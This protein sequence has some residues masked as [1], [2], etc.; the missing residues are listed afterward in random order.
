M[1]SVAQP[2]TRAMGKCLELLTEI[3]P[4]VKRAALIFNPDTAPGGRSYYYLRP[5]QTPGTPCPW[6]R[7]N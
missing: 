6:R 1:R 7:C 2:G 4:S 5:D 3:A